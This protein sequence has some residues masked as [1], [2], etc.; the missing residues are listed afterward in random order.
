[1]PPSL[2]WWHGNSDGIGESNIGALPICGESLTPVE[3][4]MQ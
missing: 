4:L 1:M 2:S 3:R